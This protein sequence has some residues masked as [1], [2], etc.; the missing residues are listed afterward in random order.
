MAT[1]GRNGVVKIGSTAIG[2]VRSW[3]LDH[4]SD[5]IDTTTMSTA[6]KIGRAHV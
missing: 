1:A 2:S 6:G 3:T 4:K 5:T